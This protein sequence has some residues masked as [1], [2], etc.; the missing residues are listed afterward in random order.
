M[1]K[2]KEKRLTIPAAALAFVLLACDFAS[3]A[4]EAPV[5]L[6]SELPL[7]SVL[8]FVGML[9]SIA[10]FPLIKPH[11]W[12]RNL[13][14]VAIFWSLVFFIPFAFAFGPSE[15]LSE[16]LE[17]VL[18]DYLPFIV[19]LWGLFAVAGGILLK[20]ELSGTPKV[21][22]VLLLIGTLLASWVGTTGAS[23]LLIRPVIRA[24]R[25]REK[26]AHVVIFF[27]F[28]VS[29]IGGCLTPVGDPPLFLGFL[30]GV[31]FFW[32]MRLAPMMLVNVVI[33][34][35]LLFFMDSRLYKKELA[36]GRRPEQSASKEPLRVEG[37]HNLIFIALIVFSVILSGMVAKSAPF[38]D[39]ATG[40]QL[41]IPVYGHI[42]VPFN[43]ILQMALI[44]IAGVLS[45]VTTKK[46][47]REANLFTWG[48][49]KE[50]ASLFI[51]IFITMIPA[52]AILNA[53]GAELGLTKAWQFFWATGAL[54]SFLDNAPTYLVFMTTAGSLGAAEGLS[55]AVGTIAPTLLLAISAGAVF[56]GA[57]TYIGNAP[58]FMV[59]SIAEENSIK[60]PSFFGYMKWSVGILVPLFIIDMLIFFI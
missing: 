55:T 28:L 22:L 41:G 20:G 29:N 49:I 57:N 50:V 26:K 18:L 47:L 4:E 6:G 35:A 15:A 53:R 56:M 19:L 30:R 48:P 31:P 39:A 27:I 8:P 54:S 5:E 16:L 36:A 42:V 25:W 2:K 52:L 59:R 46:A 51:G 60:M 17:I 34:L 45:V 32:T 12:E 21:N 37:L 7:W 1:K 44:V 40:Q 14:K 11:W 10:I 9:L 3:A 58:N 43:S 24:N 38:Y 23:M 33:L 13:L